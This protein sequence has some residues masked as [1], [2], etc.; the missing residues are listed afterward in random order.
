MRHGLG[1]P[2]WGITIIQNYNNVFFVANIYHF[3]EEL[4]SLQ[5]DDDGD[6]GGAA[7][8]G[9]EWGIVNQAK[10]SQAPSRVCSG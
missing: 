6:G 5:Y 2:I 8:R 9:R 1:A 10:W 3:F 4:S 7:V